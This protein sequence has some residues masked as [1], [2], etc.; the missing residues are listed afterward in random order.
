MKPRI[1]FLDLE[2]TLIEVPR[3]VSSEIPKSMWQSLARMLGDDCL[4]EEE[5][6]HS[7]WLRGEIPNYLEWMN[8]TVE[9]FCRHGLRRDAIEA[10]V[11]SLKLTAGVEEFARRMHEQGAIL[12]IVT[13]ALKSVAE[14][15]QILIKAQHLFAGCELYFDSAGSVLHWNLLPS[16]WFGKVDF[17]NLLIREYGAQADDCVFIGDGINDVELARRMGLSIAFNADDAL[18]KVAD[19]VISQPIGQASFDGIATIIERFWRH[20]SGV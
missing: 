20:E 4:R 3:V 19:V 14:P 5:G 6:S 10:L 1:V 12:A 16:D 9:M 18:A 17:M 2:G 11:R 13:G 15:V 8:E 7:R